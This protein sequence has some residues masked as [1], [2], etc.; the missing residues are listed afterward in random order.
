MK[1]LYNI[2]SVDKQSTPEQI[3]RAYKKAAFQYHPDK[4]NDTDAEEKFQDISEAYDILMDDDKR[5]MYDNFGYDSISGDIPTIN[6]MDLFQSLFNVDFTGDGMNSNIFVF[7]DLS[8]QPF[9]PLINKMTYNL[10]CNLNELYHGHKKE[11]NIVHM[12]QKGKKSTKYIIN[13]K[14]G[15]KNDDNIVVKEGG[16][17]IPELG[18]IED[19]VIKIVEVEHPKY[20]R[21]GHDLFIQENISLCEAL[22]GCTLYIEHLDGPLQVNITDMIKPNQLFQVFG[23][24]MPIKMDNKSLTSTGEEVDYGN[25]I[26][27]LN[28]IFP[29]SLSEKQLELLTKILV[30]LPREERDGTIC[31][32]YYYKD[33]SSPIKELINEDD[34]DS[35]MG[36]TQQ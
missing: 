4:N 17:F 15:S 28:I 34:G 26:I 23:K 6:P 1:D 12:T 20:K 7:S 9:G 36:C 22:Q 3:K 24:G 31:H 18:I 32:G 11:F 27:D 19:L 16:N 14:K 30:Q 33:K 2:L 35:G 21:S 13:I 10:E 5:R 29:D 25:L 8:T